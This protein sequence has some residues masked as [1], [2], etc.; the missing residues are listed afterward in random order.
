MGALPKRRI[1]KRRKGNRRSH[2][3]LANPAMSVCPK[4]GKVKRPHFKCAYCGFYGEFKRK[5][6]AEAPVAAVAKVAKAVKKATA[7]AE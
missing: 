7:K 4:C 1:S 3:A 6:V 2:Y 5:T